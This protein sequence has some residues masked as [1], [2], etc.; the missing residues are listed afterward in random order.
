MTNSFIK[1]LVLVKH[2]Y[3]LYSTVYILVLFIL[4]DFG[5]FISG[6]MKVRWGG[7]GGDFIPSNSF[8]NFL[9]MLFL[10]FVILNEIL[11]INSEIRPRPSAYTCAQF[12][13]SHS[14]LD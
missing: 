10:P 9:S 3:R 14:F 7:A 4:H 13:G 8:Q 6:T 11:K 5:W 1:T 2:W 12:I